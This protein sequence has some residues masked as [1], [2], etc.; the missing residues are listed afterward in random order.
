M[1]KADA[2]LT[3]QQVRFL[4][5]EFYDNF[6]FNEIDKNIIAYSGNGKI[7]IRISYKESGYFEPKGNK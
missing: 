6:V 1:I 7:C 4:I 3:R 5:D 2:N